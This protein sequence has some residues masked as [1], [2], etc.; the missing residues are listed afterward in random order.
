[1]NGTDGLKKNVYYHAAAGALF[2][3]FLF[4]ALALAGYREGLYNGV[5][6]LVK[7]R[8]NLISMEASLAEMKSVRGRISGIVRAD[9]DKRSNREILL[10]SLE[11]ALKEMP[12]ATATVTGFVEEGAEI[13]LPVVIEFPVF[14]YYDAVR[15]IGYLEGMSFPYF[16]VKGAAIRRV[17]GAGRVEGRVEGT[18]R[19]PSERIRKAGGG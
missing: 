7:I 18:F 8:R 9:Y 13:A 6:S 4:M 1:M 17:E 14:N 15:N 5:D 10:L 11:D 19:M 2:A 12:G 3:L 16:S